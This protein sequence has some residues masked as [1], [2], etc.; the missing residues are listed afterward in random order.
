MREIVHSLD[1]ASLKSW[2]KSRQ[3]LMPAYDEK[4]LPEKTCGPAG[5]LVSSAAGVRSERQTNVGL[6]SLTILA[7]TAGAQ[8]TSERLSNAGQEPQNWLMY[9]GDY[10][11]GRFLRC[12]KLKLEMRK[13]GAEVGLS[14][15]GWRKI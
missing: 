5:V 14:N 9:S 4:T 6:S 7:A 1:K 2:K 12:R 13:A 15:H 3:S 10:A 11:G 8:V